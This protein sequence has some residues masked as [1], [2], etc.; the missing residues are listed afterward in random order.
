MGHQ[1][2]CFTN[3]IRSLEPLALSLLQHDQITCW[4]V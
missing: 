2:G 4:R 1:D 3:Q